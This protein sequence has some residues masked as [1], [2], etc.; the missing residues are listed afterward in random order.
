MEPVAGEFELLEP[1]GA[2]AERGAGPMQVEVDAEKRTAALQIDGPA[3]F[4][5]D[6]DDVDGV[7]EDGPLAIRLALAGGLALELTKLGRQRDALLRELRGAWR[8]HAVDRLRLGEAEAPQRFEAEVTRAGATSPAEVRVFGTRLAVVTDAGA[9]FAQPLGSLT[10]VKFDE[11]AYAVEL[12]AAEGAWRIAKLGKQTQ[13][14]LRLLE[15]RR[16]ALHRRAGTALQLLLPSLDSLTLRRLGALLPDGGVATAAA[17]DAIKPGT[18]AALARVAAVTP[19]LKKSIGA[20]QKSAAP[21]AA[22]CIA[23][24]REPEE[25]AEPDV[26]LEAASEEEAPAPPNP[27]LEKRAVG[28]IF[29]LAG[30][31]ALAVEVGGHAGKATYVFRGGAEQA[32]AL[33]ADW[34]QLDWKREPIYLGED[35]LC[36]GPHGSWRMALRRSEP[37]KRL[38]AAYLGRVKHDGTW[39]ANLDKLAAKAG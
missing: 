23:E 29:P 26:E 34:A 22:V 24:L 5:L 31:R 9:A 8:T 6:L 7:L 37:L 10:A 3:P 1:G 20:L 11:G 39:Q 25:D 28:L 12:T 33:L 38:R 4:R 32:G 16:A 15:D 2:Q 35:K 14:F 30:G 19:A 13:P 17:L 36:A 21:G 27:G 18:F